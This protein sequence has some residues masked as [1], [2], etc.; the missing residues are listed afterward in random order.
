M[1]G[2]PSLIVKRRKVANVLKGEP[3]VY[4]NAVIGGPDEACL[5]RVITEEDQ[6]LGWA[7]YNP[8]APVKARILLRREIWPGDQLFTSVFLENAIT[9]RLRLGMSVQGGAFRLVNGEGDGMPGLVI[10]QF[11][12]HIVIDI[13][14]L[15]MLRRLE[16]IQRGLKQL[17]DDSPQVVRFGEDAAK[18]E[19]CDPI[20]FAGD[21]TLRFAE[22]G[23]YY[24]VPLNKTQKTGFYLDQRENRRLVARYAADRS[25]LDLFS[26]QG[27]FALS[28]LAGGAVDALAVDSSQDALNMALAHAER[29]SLDLGIYQ[30]DVFDFFNHVDQPFD[31]IVCDPPKLAPRKSNKEKAMSAYRHLSK[32]CL[33]VLS[34]NGLL[35]ISSCSQ[36]I[37]HDDLRQVVL[38]QAN[39]LG[40]TLDV[41][42][43]THQPPDHPWPLAFET[44]RYLSS[45][46]LEQRLV[47]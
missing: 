41:I 2:E 31:L 45:L 24:E 11:G 35:L 15:G 6:F 37:Q 3:W 19:K 5:V 29:N 26:Y 23:V 18:R 43:M 40:M 4:P 13:Y 16:F 46:L 1:S 39:K 30:S 47:Q 25:V 33:E 21:V 10:D 36:S 42:A 27:G 17:L 7:D 8:D 9:R 34:D 12:H 38:Q 44:G 28:A 20:P 22:N 14:S 32:K